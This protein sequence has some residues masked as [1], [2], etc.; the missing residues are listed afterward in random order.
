MN[1]HDSWLV[2]HMLDFLVHGNSEFS[3]PACVY[4]TT[5]DVVCYANKL[6]V[7]LNVNN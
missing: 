5:S 1:E 7:L 3:W 6:E 2:C 4:I